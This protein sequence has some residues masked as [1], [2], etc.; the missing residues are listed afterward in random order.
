MK[1]LR[2]LRFGSEKLLALFSFERID[3]LKLFCHPTACE[4]VWYDVTCALPCAKQSVHTSF[5]LKKE[6]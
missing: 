5:A 4:Q 1:L 3:H 6:Q 2:F